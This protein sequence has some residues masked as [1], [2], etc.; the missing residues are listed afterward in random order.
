MYGNHRNSS[1]RIR[2]RVAQ[3]RVFLFI[4]LLGHTV[5]SAVLTYAQDGTAQMVRREEAAT[6]PTSLYCRQSKRKQ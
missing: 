2:K 5:V 4:R 1:V 6:S 3:K